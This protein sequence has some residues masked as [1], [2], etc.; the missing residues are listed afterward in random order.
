MLVEIPSVSADPAH[1]GQLLR[2]AEAASA[3][4][5]AYGAEAR[6]LPTEGAP[7]VTGFFKSDPSHPTI[8][9]YNHLDVQP[10]N[11]PEWRT[12]PFKLLIENDVYRG[13]GTTDDKGPALTAL[14]GAVAA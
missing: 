8:T 12:D 7:L 6:V 1:K 9:V 3:L 11:E 5:N 14:L 2:C 4:L 10:A 13:R